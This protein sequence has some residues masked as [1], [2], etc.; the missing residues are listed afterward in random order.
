[1]AASAGGSSSAQYEVIQYL[2]DTIYVPKPV[3]AA[4][5]Q[6][7]GPLQGAESE[8]RD[9]V[10]QARESIKEMMAELK[11]TL[12]KEVR[13]R[14][15]QRDSGS[16]YGPPSGS[17]GYRPAQRR[18]VPHDE[19]GVPAGRPRCQRCRR[20]HPGHCWRCDNCGRFGHLAASCRIEYPSRRPASQYQPQQPDNKR[21]RP[22][23]MG[24]GQAN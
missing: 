22:E 3:M 4:Q 18:Y 19:R 17:N 10:K 23:Q 12:G 8:V 13:G 24:G 2:D 14:D 15:A 7:R 6:L 20:S 11:E 21:Q 9:M 5:T 1:M 16:T